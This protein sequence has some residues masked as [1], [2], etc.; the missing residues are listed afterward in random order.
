MDNL[1]SVNPAAP[2][3]PDGR[4]SRA[5]PLF[6]PLPPY[7]SRMNFLGLSATPFTRTS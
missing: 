6:A 5:K 7:S 3:K 1:R 4:A 2:V